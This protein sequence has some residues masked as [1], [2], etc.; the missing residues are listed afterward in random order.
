VGSFSQTAIV[1]F[2]RTHVANKLIEIG[3]ISFRGLE[4]HVFSST[5]TSKKCKKTDPM[6]L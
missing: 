5:K 6:L 1:T 4:V 3:I 2:E